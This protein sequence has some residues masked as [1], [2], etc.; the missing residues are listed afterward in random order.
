M[1]EKDMISKEEFISIMEKELEER[2]YTEEFTSRVN[3]VM[4]KFGSVVPANET[5]ED[6]VEEIETENNDGVETSSFAYKKSKKV[7]HRA[8]Q[9]VK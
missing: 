9:N 8:I 1:A 3:A 4:E 2:E 5:V 6:T 7:R